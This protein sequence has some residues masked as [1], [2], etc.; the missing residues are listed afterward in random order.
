MQWRIPNS[1]LDYWKNDGL[2]TGGQY[3]SSQGCQPYL[4]PKCEH[5]IPGPYPPCG[6]IA[7]TPKCSKQCEAGYSKSFTNDLHFG[8]SAYSVSDNVKEIQT[9]IMTNGP[10]EA[11]FEVYSDFLTYKSG[12][13]QHKSG[14]LLGGHAVKI[15]GWG[16]ENGTPYWLVANSWNPTWGE[17]G[18]FKIL[19]G[20]DEVGIES[21]IVAGMPKKY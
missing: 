16:T 5:H 8:E 13:Y 1:C 9:E 2:V 18:Y 14:S 19:R 7:K 12:V 6:S 15:L 20:D 4:I 17:N 11:A 3:N 21:G 10:V